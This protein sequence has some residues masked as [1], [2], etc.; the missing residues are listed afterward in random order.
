M[1][2]IE[3]HAAEGGEDAQAFATE[4]ASSVSKFA[5]LTVRAGTRVVTLEARGRL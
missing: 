2:T 1:F 5:P 3:F 4:L